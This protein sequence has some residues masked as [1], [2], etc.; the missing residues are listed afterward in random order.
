MGETVDGLIILGVL[1]FNATVGAYQEGRAQNTLLALKRF[2]VTNALVLRGGREM[3]IDEAEVVPGDVIVLREGDKVPGDARVVTSNNLTLDEAALTG[4]SAAVG[5]T[6][7]T[8]PE[9]NLQTGD[10]KNMVFKGTY[11]VAGNGTVVVTAT[12]LKSVLGK[13]AK[14]IE[15][16]DTEIPLKAN[17][18]YLSGAIVAVVVAVCMVLFLAGVGT[19]REAVEM[20]A[21]VVSLAVSI[22]P[23]GLPIVMT[24]VLATGVNR[25]SKR[26]VLVKKL[27]AVEALGQA[28]VIAVDK[29]GTLTKNEISV[30]KV[31][32]GGQVFN[33]E[34]DGYTPVGKVY[35]EEREVDPGKQEGLATWFWTRNPNRGSHPGIQ[36][37]RD[38]QYLPKDLV[39]LKTWRIGGGLGSR[40]YL[41]TTETN[42]T[43]RRTK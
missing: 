43:R 19:G 31:Y 24:L 14:E 10:Q 28:R 36:Q 35:L 34:G 33:I 11:V 18:R 5:K 16:V 39:F 9:E 22:I 20:F 12:G 32:T 1:F 8:L 40:R 4:E 13:I 3:L 2:S 41:L 15:G 27:H 7:D 6:V 26:Q 21:V 25:M 29:T 23:E 17:V 42:I 38:W 30:Q 37:M